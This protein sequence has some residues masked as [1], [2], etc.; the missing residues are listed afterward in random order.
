[1]YG[2]RFHP[3][4]G[5]CRLGYRFGDCLRSPE[6][7]QGLGGI[8]ASS[9]RYRLTLIHCS[10][11]FSSAPA[12]MH[13]SATRL[14]TSVELGLADPERDARQLAQKVGPAARDPTQLLDGC[15]VLL[16]RVRDPPR[17]MLGN[18]PSHCQQCGQRRSQPYR[19]I[20]TP[21]RED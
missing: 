9:A 11:F 1:M 10:I 4:P 16:R 15:H 13:R 18:A 8:F 3:G 19:H 21:V 2:A 14:Y 5:S 12:S 17:Q 7:L 20:R 6:L